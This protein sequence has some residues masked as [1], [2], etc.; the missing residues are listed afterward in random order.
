MLFYLPERIY[1]FVKDSDEYKLIN[2]TMEDSFKGVNSLVD[3]LTWENNLE[4]YSELFF[5]EIELM[6]GKIPE[7]MKLELT[8]AS[9]YK[10]NKEKLLS[11]YEDLTQDNET[12]L[13][14]LSNIINWSYDDR[15][16]PIYEDMYK[17]YYENL[18]W[19]EV[20]EM[21]SYIHLKYMV[22]STNSLCRNIKNKSSVKY[23]EIIKTH[24]DECRNKFKEI[25]NKDILDYEYL[26]IFS[27][28]ITLMTDEMDEDI[29]AYSALNSTTIDD[30]LF[31]IQYGDYSMAKVAILNTKFELAYFC[32]D[33]NA[34]SI[35]FD[36]L[37]KYTDLGLAN[38]GKLI[39]G[40]MIY[41][42]IMIEMYLVSLK[43]LLKLSE[44]IPSSEK[45]TNIKN[46]DLDLVSENKKDFSQISKLSDPIIKSFQKTFK[47]SEDW[48]NNSKELLLLF[49]NYYE[50]I[51]K[52]KKKDP[53]FSLDRE[54]IAQ[55]ITESKEEGFTRRAYKV[56]PL[57]TKRKVPFPIKEEDKDK[58]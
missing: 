35:Y 24:L 19:D 11:F 31:N 42:K 16:F 10:I 49:K 33:F 20:K 46:I 6:M 15:T 5:N 52:Y 56:F 38:I 2:K 41:D 53:S 43:R 39:R 8:I 18:E 26:E 25:I 17:S 9:N 7:N 13:F 57:S 40:L 58:K 37:V 3:A 34:A 51:Y 29:D 48:F 32:R 14:I 28:C 1:K 12:R 22:S 50:N 36:L 54:F 4:K 44:Y 55:A 45:I 27:H 30:D 23:L 47:H 21:S